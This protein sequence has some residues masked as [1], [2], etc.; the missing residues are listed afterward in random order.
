MFGDGGLCLL[1]V[2]SYS[3]NIFFMHL[4]CYRVCFN[5]LEAEV[6]SWPLE[7]LEIHFLFFVVAW[8]CGMAPWE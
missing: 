1:T 3:K 2:V 8:M 5:V 6:S 7:G 4:I